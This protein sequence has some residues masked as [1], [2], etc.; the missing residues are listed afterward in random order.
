MSLKISLFG[1]GCGRFLGGERDIQDTI[2][3]HLHFVQLLC[4][5]HD[6]LG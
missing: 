5:L 4:T 6:L 1:N 2:L 3:S